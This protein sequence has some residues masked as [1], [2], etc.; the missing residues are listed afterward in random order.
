MKTRGEI[1]SAFLDTWQFMGEVVEGATMRVDGPV[2]V[3]MTG[4][5]IPT[6]NGLWSTSA[7]ISSGRLDELLSEV[8]PAIPHCVQ[9]PADA[10]P[11][12]LTWLTER[13][14]TRT[15]DI[16]L[17][18]LDARAEPQSTSLRIRALEPDEVGLHARVAAAGFGAPEELFQRLIAPR[19]AASPGATVAVGE[20]GGELVTTGVSVTVNGCVGVFNIAT[21]EAERGRGYG[22]AVTCWLV[23]RGFESGG[24]VAWLQSS[25]SGFGVYQ[26]LGFRVVDT[27]QC[28][29]S[30]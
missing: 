14:M 18:A 4:L 13:G 15:D 16:P 23:A 19:F 12:V 22:A 20:A 21:P 5:P 8:D 6:L 29:I 28:W 3:G 9:L 26:R 17:M 2:A 1:G 27:W 7:D 30:S 25:T 24:H 11:E 10:P